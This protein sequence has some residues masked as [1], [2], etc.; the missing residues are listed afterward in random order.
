MLQRQ[1]PPGT[2]VVP[3]PDER[4]VLKPGDD[5]RIAL[6]KFQNYGDNNA[7]SL[8]DALKNYEVVRQRMATGE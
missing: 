2:W 8:R 4:P 7:Q 3:L 5:A 1:L 6:R